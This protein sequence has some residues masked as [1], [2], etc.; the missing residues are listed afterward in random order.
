L[1]AFLERF[2]KEGKG[3]MGDQETK[4]KCIG[5]KDGKEELRSLMAEGLHDLEECL[6]SQAGYEYDRILKFR[7][8]ISKLEDD[9][10]DLEKAGQLSPVE[11]MSLHKLMTG[12]MT[13]SLAFLQKLNA[14]LAEG[15]ESINF[16]EKLQKGLKDI[17][18]DDNGGDKKTRGEL[19]AMLLK[20]IKERVEAGERGGGKGHVR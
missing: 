13:S 12:N 19:R 6:F 2:E 1:I 5:T 3:S 17:P 20:K 14:S 16:I 10:L 8:T 11:K 7:E 4:E 9:L 18:R 15:I